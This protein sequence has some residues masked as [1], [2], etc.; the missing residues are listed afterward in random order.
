LR[1]IPQTAGK[2]GTLCG[3][4]STSEKRARRIRDDG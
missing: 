4:P 1:R 2:L 3:M